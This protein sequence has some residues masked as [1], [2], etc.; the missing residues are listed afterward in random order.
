MSNQPTNVSHLPAYASRA[1]AR[2]APVGGEQRKFVAKGHDAQLQDAQH[3]RL[4][5]TLVT[6]A[7]D[8]FNGTVI[9]RDKFTITLRLDSGE[10][11]IFYKHAIES[12]TIKRNAA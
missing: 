9:K 5:T 2:P 4:D 10:E 11:T 12:I 7:G 6:L 1:G 3:N 8:T